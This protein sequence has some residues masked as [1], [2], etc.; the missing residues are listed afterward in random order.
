[1]D[2]NYNNYSNILSNP[3]LAKS[4]FDENNNNFFFE[5]ENNINLNTGVKGENKFGKDV[6]NV[7]N[8]NFLFNVFQNPVANN[9]QNQQGFYS[10]NNSPWRSGRGFNNNENFSLN[11][12]MNFP[13]FEEPQY[14][15]HQM[16][17]HTPGNSP[18]RMRPNFNPNY[19]EQKKSNFHSKQNKASL[20]NNLDKE[21]KGEEFKDL[22]ELLS[23]IDCEL[24]LYASSQK[25][26]RNLQKLLN[27]IL[28]H[29]LDVILEKIKDHF[30]F[31]MTDTY[32]NYFCQKL[33]QCC[34]SEQRVFILKHVKI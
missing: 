2:F 17:F 24:W 31:L 28:P 19:S 1:M 10:A 11:N 12:S 8:D 22:E 27:K 23:S 3:N 6:Q 14:L 16:Q 21:E 9:F 34:S 33:I 29:E 7:R 30:A 5:S 13:G 4:K 15:K 18:G 25:G 20:F 32:G 26:S